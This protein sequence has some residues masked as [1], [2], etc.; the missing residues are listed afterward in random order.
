[1]LI[2]PVTKTNIQPIKMHSQMLQKTKSED[3][4]AFENKFVNKKFLLDRKILKENEDINSF[5]ES[6]AAQIFPDSNIKHSFEELL[7]H[8]YVALSTSAYSNLSDPKSAIALRLDK[9]TSS[10]KHCSDLEKYIKNGVGIGLNLSELD[11]P[12]SEIKILN[13]YFKYREPNLNRPSAGI[14][15]LNVTHPKIMDFIGLKD[16]A[17]Y[18]D[19]CFDLSVIIDSDFLSK[20]DNNQDLILDDGTKINANEVYFKL[21]NSMRKSGEPGVIFSSDK[22]FICDSCA[23]SKLEENEGLNLAQ[24]NLA[25][26]YNKKTKN[27]DYEFLAQS[28]NVLSLALKKIAPNGFISIL[29]YQDLLNQMGLIYGSK[30]ALEVLENML[31]VIKK[32]AQKENLRMCISPSGTTSRILKTTPSIEPKDNI[33]ATY[34][35]EIETMAAAQKY[36][37]G[38]ISKT[39]NLKSKHTIQDIDLIIRACFKQ[40]I[41]GISVFPS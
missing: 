1:M 10:Y 40:G 33:Y 6:I 8:G 18:D 39:I 14:A 29:G 28:A 32:E 41:K 16:S 24:I 3:V 2:T 5:Y 36:L 23:A 26:F 21:L 37:E 35:D 38:G 13:S 30:E 11:N 12:I 15:L 19:W 7:K 25:K 4:C 31:N 20:V 17:N 9:R 27:I 22:D 34:W